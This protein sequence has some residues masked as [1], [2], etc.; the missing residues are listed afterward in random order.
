MWPLVLPSYNIVTV[1]AMNELFL[2]TIFSVLFSFEQFLFILSIDIFSV[3]YIKV[4]IS[5]CY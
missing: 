4:F 2:F 5:L 1:V 3:V